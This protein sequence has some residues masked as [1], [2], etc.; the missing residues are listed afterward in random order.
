[1]FKYVKE[2]YKAFIVDVDDMELVANFAMEG[3]FKDFAVWLFEKYEKKLEDDEEDPDQNFLEICVN[4]YKDYI[5]DYSKVMEVLKKGLDL[6]IYFSYWIMEETVDILVINGKYEEVKELIQNYIFKNPSIRKKFIKMFLQGIESKE[7]IKEVGPK[8][9]EIIDNFDINLNSGKK[10]KRRRTLNI[11]SEVNDESKKSLHSNS[12]IKVKGVNSFRD[13]FLSNQYPGKVETGRDYTQKD[14]PI[15]S[16][17]EMPDE[18]EDNVVLKNRKKFPMI[19][20]LSSDS[21]SFQV[22]QA[23]HEIQAM[24]KKHTLKI[25]EKQIKESSEISYDSGDELDLDDDSLCME[26]LFDDENEESPMAFFDA[27]SEE[28]PV[29]K[30]AKKCRIVD[31]LNPNEEAEIIF[32]DQ[33]DKQKF[34][35]LKKDC[36]LSMQNIQY[37]VYQKARWL[38]KTEDIHKGIDFLSANRFVFY[39]SFTKYLFK[40]YKNCL[41]IDEIMDL[42]GRFFGAIK[43][44]YFDYMNIKKVV[45]RL[46]YNF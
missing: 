24:L 45:F 22:E 4:F 28:E 40:I 5:H 9:D 38:C 17:L 2:N 43:R 27:F 41:Q 21:T 8:I 34:E 42:E 33:K 11:L 31:L 30:K 16:V 46:S 1:M 20:A 14:V 26:N 19:S 44:L 13:K 15:T 39:G 36:L 6:E 25:S 37:L 12:L 18:K 7:G 10:N 3:G 29:S 23:K 35:K 32:N